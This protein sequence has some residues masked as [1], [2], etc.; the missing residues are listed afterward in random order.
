[1]SKILIT[2]GAGYIGSHTAIELFQ[3]TDFEVVSIDNYSN[4][5]PSA[6]DRIAQISGKS[7]KNY[8]VDVCNLEELRK[9]FA[10]NPDIVGVI[11][12]AAYKAVG[13][14]VANP[15]KY[16]HNNFASLVNML[17]CCQEAKVHNF[18]FSSSCT[19]YGEISPERL[20]VSEN[21]ITKEANCPY[22]TTKLVGEQILRDFAL[23]NPQ[24]KFLLL[25]YFNPVG[26][27]ISGL[28]GEEP[29]N[30]PNNLVPMITQ[31]AVGIIEKMTVF[32]GNYPTRDG[33]CIRDY[34]HVTDIAVAHLKALQ[35]SIDDKIEGNL[36]V[37]NLGSGEGVS[38]LEAI[39]AF[40]KVSE[41]KLNYEIGAA[42]PGDVAAIYSDSS[43][44]WQKLGWKTQFSIEEMMASAWKWQLYLKNRGGN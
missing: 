39:N 4:S 40:E 6:L 5:S 19:V 1:M 2:G 31:T 21:T 29:I 16:Y 24:M 35:Y 13:E 38:V 18:V 43:K 20:P 14:S 33:T 12:F 10:E 32:G 26:G 7:L 44:A 17:Q 11:H 42:R 27:H 15:L 41:V 22:G 36:E 3:Q 37:F 9:V 25:R 34:I 30:R 8:V 28:N 23:A